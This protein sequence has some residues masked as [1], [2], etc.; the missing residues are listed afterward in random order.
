MSSS[1]H[2]RWE[3]LDPV[4]ESS[5]HETSQS[6]HGGDQRINHVETKM[7]EVELTFRDKPVAIDGSSS[8]IH[9]V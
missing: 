6:G 5:I 4:S 2:P 9:A 3:K 7:V 8:K 1:F